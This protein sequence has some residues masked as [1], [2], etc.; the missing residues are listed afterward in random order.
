M[1]SFEWKGFS[2]WL[3]SKLINFYETKLGFLLIKVRLLKI[4]IIFSKKPNNF[5]EF[6]KEIPF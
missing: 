1:F 5:C 3:N 2:L 6:I 4:L